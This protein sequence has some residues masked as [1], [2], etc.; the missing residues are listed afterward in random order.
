MGGREDCRVCLWHASP[1]LP[2]ELLEFGGSSDPQHEAHE[3]AHIHAEQARWLEAVRQAAE[4]V[5]T[6]AKHFLHEAGVPADAVEMQMTATVYTQDIVL[7]MLEA[8][9]AQQCGTVV[10]GRESLHG[11]RALLT[12]HLS[13]TLIRQAH[14]LTVWVVE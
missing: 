8:A 12:S 9:R 10:V 3:E 4:P 2:R 5:F 11:L 14:D 6:R 7:H 1:P 13:D